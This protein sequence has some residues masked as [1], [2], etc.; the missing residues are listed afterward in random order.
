[1]NRLKSLNQISIDFEK[2]A[3]DVE[4]RY[5]EKLNELRKQL[6]HKWRQI[7]KF[8][9]SVKNLSEMKQSWKRKFALKDGEIDALK[10]SGIQKKSVRSLP[11][12]KKINCI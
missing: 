10:V 5:T 2:R 1:M 12:S 9:G 6:D 8:E 4:T 7:D 11:L 3:K